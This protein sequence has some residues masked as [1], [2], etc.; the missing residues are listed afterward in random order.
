MK[1]RIVIAFDGRNFFGWQAQ[2]NKRTVQGELTSAARAVFGED[3]TVTGCSRT[4]SGVHA[5]GFTAMIEGRDFPVDKIVLALN[6]SL[7]DDISVLSAQIAPDDF[8]PRYSV[9]AKTYEYLI[10]CGKIRNPFCRGYK[11]QYCRDVDVGRINEAC[12]KLIGRHDFTAFMAS[13]SKITDAVREIYSCSAE[14]DGDTLKITV[15]GN[16]FLYNMVRIIAGT[17]LS[18]SE[19]RIS[20]DDIPKIIESKNRFNAGKTLPPDGLYLV[21]ADY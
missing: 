12:G 13:G 10:Y 2:K 20:P 19:G 14:L 4:D 18:V 17:L 9:R 6:Y 3:A 15:T 7:P 21:R 5:L 11:Y 16:G 1:Y 8:H